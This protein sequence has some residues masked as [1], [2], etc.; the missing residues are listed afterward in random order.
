MI[1]FIDLSGNC[2]FLAAISALT[3][4]KNVL[5]QV[6]PLEQSFDSY[7]GIFHFRVW[8]TWNLL[9]IQDIFR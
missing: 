9:D 4:H 8:K 3:F 6:V 1:H 5:G 2:W 7:A